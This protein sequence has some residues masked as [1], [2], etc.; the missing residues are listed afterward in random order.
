LRQNLPWLCPG[1]GPAKTSRPN[2]KPLQFGQ[3]WQNNFTP[4][5]LEAEPAALTFPLATSR[6]FKMFPALQCKVKNKIAVSR[7]VAADDIAQ[8]Y[9][10]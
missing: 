10:G 1:R 8:M 2:Q 5:Q 4:V 9:Q 3:Q 7:K 6:L